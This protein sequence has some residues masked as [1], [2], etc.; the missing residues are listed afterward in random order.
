MK[1]LWQFIKFGIVGVSNTLI[2]EVIYAIVVC[3]HGHYIV[4]NFLGFSISVLNAYYWGNR[5]VFKQKQGEE[6]R[7]WWKVLLKTYVAY[8]GGFLLNIGLL[9]LWVEVVDLSQFMEPVVQL[10]NNFS[11][12]YFDREMLGELAAQMLSLPIVV[13]VNYLMNKYWA[14]RQKKEREE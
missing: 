13:P 1:N 7:I 11:V 3:L 12:T 2:S 6:K 5:F 8:I 9:F 10:L 14:Y 4:A